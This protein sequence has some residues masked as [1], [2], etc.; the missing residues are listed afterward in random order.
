VCLANSL[1][2]G[3]LCV[4]GREVLQAG[5][6]AWLRPV[7]A[8]PRAELTYLEYHYVD[9][10]GPALLDVI[11]VPLLKASPHA[12]QTEN[13]LIDPSRRW[14]KIGRCSFSRL[15]SLLERPATLWRNTGQTAFGRYNCVDWPEASSERTSLLLVDGAGLAVCVKP[16][17]TG[18]KSFYGEFHFGGEFYRLCITD[19]LVRDHF[20]TCP[21]GRYPFPAVGRIFL[22]VSLT[23]PYEGDGRCH[24]LIAAVIAEHSLAPS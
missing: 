4:A 22:C 3:G 2:E 16:G 19:P 23:E 18:R 13:H 1:K 7:S 12:H 20:D 6:G 8:R 21:C 15:P 14:S 17:M 24:K 9:G 5:F 10:S 11:D